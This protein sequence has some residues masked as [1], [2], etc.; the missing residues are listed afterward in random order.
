VTFRFTLADQSLYLPN[1][2]YT[3]DLHSVGAAEAA[4][5]I[6]IRIRECYRFGLYSL[7]VAYGTPGHVGQFEGSILERLC[8]IVLSDEHVFQSALPDWVFDAR[9]RTQWPIFLLLSIKPNPSPDTIDAS[10]KFENFHAKDEKLL[11]QKLLCTTPYQ[12]L[13][14]LYDWT[15]AARAIRKSCDVPCNASGLASFCS[16]NGRGNPEANGLSLKDLMYAADHYNEWAGRPLPPPQP[17]APDSVMEEPAPIPIPPMLPT[18][19]DWFRLFDRLV[20]DGD[21]SHCATVIDK[22]ECLCTTDE[23]KY[24][25]ALRKGTLLLRTHDASS[26]TW[27]LKAD[28]A[29]VTLFGE[30]S[31]RRLG[32]IGML[33][34]W[35]AISGEAGRVLQYGEIAAQYFR[36]T[37]HWSREKEFRNALAVAHSLRL[38]GDIPESE[39]VLSDAAWRIILQNEDAASSDFSVDYRAMCN[40]GLPPKLLA[41]FFFLGALNAT[42]SGNRTA[43]QYELNAAIEMAQKCSDHSLLARLKVEHG[44]MVRRL[45][46]DSDA[47]LK[48]YDEAEQQNDLEGAPDVYIRFLVNLNRG[49]AHATIGDKESLRQARRAYARAEKDAAE[50]FIEDHAELFQLY[51]SQSGLHLRCGEY[52]EAIEKA[53]KASAILELKAPDRVTGIGRMHFYKGQAYVKLN[54]FKQALVCLNEAKKCFNISRDRIPEELLEGLHTAIAIARRGIAGGHGLSG[55]S[56]G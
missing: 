9:E 33:Q 19:D 10:I 43:A 25:F 47:A 16:Q 49:V 35:Y 29:C 54:R 22:M 32:I 1:R 37:L 52:Y 15:Y 39:G 12:P 21:Y 11:S 53:E 31:P 28:A 2:L 56:Q 48:L 44:R 40:C 36:N 50:C 41:N 45:E 17:T 5:I 46:G 20:D 18:A 24:E 8:D 26:E 13:R 34:D 38:T 30:A 55:E 23:T 14:D 27:L 51:S 4:R 42:D 7:K 3:L 6:R